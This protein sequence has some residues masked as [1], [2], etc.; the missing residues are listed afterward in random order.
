MKKIIALA[1]ASVLAL[2]STIF[3][4]ADEVIKLPDP[5]AVYE[6]DDASGL[7]VVSE[8]SGTVDVVEDRENGVGKGEVLHVPA[9]GDTDTEVMLPNPFAGWDLTEGSQTTDVRG[10]NYEKDDVGM[11]IWYDGAVINYW[12][13]TA[14]E[15]NSVI[16]NFRDTN[17]L[18]YNKDDWRKHVVAVE[19]KEAYDKAKETGEPIDSRFAL[20]TVTVYEDEAGNEYNVY[21]GGGT[22]MGYNPDYEEGYVL[23]A[24]TL[25]VCKKGAD[26]D[27][28]D[29]WVTITTAG[30]DYF[31]AFYELDWTVNDKCEVRQGYTNG[32]LQFSLDGSIYFT[33]DDHS[34]VNINENIVDDKG[35]F[36]VRNNLKLT[37]SSDI[38][39]TLSGKDDETAGWHMVTIVIQNDWIEYYYDGYL[40]GMDEMLDAF[41]F[42]GG[43]LSGMIQGVKSFNAGF[44]PR[45]PLSRG[46]SARTDYLSG[47]RA[48]SLLTEW[49]SLESTTFSIGGTNAAALNDSFPEKVAEFWIDDVAFYDTLLTEDEVYALYEKGVE[50][51]QNGSPKATIGDVNEDGTINA[52]DA[53]L[54]L[55]YAAK[56]DI[57]A[58]KFNEAAAKTNSDDAINA[59]DALNILKYAAQMLDKLPVE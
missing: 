54:I 47:N 36:N 44:G 23:G 9:S 38:A 31:D 51:I 53:L 8:G 26:K 27:V 16:I 52:V 24:G 45:A 46:E 55:K 42:Y 39:E 32:F 57:S 11:P 22:Y 41:T 49:L 29:N 34:G 15:T 21:S 10:D 28:D 43:P 17:R 33:E 58:E 1:L 4:A 37:G 5:I 48:G 20:G 35:E 25:E 12:I 30:K 56:M 50:E 59:V 6:F 7:S 18:Q 19:A 2:S 13:K 3:V 14:D 40:Y